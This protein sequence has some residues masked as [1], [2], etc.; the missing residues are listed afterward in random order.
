MPKFAY[1]VLHPDHHTSCVVFA[2]PHSGRDYP[3]SFLRK[4]VLDEHTIRSSEDAF[5]DQLFDCAPKYGASF[6]KAGAP[7]AFIDLNRSADELDPALIEGV[8][9]SG[10]NPR[11]ASG[12]GV[13]PRVVANGRSIYR[14]KIPLAE[15]HQR[16]DRYWRPY[17]T[18]LQKMLDAAHQRHGQTVLIDCHSMPH[19]AMDGVARGGMRR[20]DVVLGDRFGAAAGGEIVDRIEAAFA[21]AGFIVTRNAPFAGAYITQAYGRPSRAQHAVQVEIDRSIYM[22]EQLIRPN[23]SFDDVRKALRTVVAEV[24]S[25]GQDRVPLAAE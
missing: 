11:I 20:P 4:T 23:G 2:S 16:I 14:G 22:N 5:V 8:R 18:Q 19:E 25:I 15:A 1:E 21:S 9:K 13:V 3:W 24:A 6:L 7:R 17:H 10:H 12:L